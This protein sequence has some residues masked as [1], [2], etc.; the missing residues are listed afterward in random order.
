MAMLL[1]NL[2]QLAL[3]FSVW[4]RASVMPPDANGLLRVIDGGWRILSGSAVPSIYPGDWFWTA[5]RA[6]TVPPGEVGPITEFPFFTF[7]YGDLHAHMIA[8]PLALFALAWAVALA[9]RPTKFSR[10]G[11][12]A[13][14]AVGALA[15]GVLYPTNSWDFPTYLV[16]TALAILFYDW[17]RLGATLPMLGQFGVKTAV[18]AA[19]SIMLFWPFWQNFGSGYG[20]VKLWE[21]SLTSIGDYLMIYGLFLWLVV[22]FVVVEFK[23]WG[24][25][26]TAEGLAKYAGVSSTAVIGLFG[27]SGIMFGMLVRGY[28][29][30]PL[31]L[32]LVLLA[33]VLAVWGAAD[34]SRR[35]V[36]TLIASALALTLV[37]E[38]VVLDGDIGRM[39]TVFKF[40]MQVWILLSIAGGA[41]LAWLWPLVTAEWGET[42]QK[43]WQTV[44]VALLLSAVLYPILATRAKWAIRENP[45]QARTTLN[46][47]DFMRYVTYGDSGQNVSLN[48]DYEAIQWMHRNIPGSP[49]IAEAHSGNPYRS[50]GNRIS[51]YTGLPSIV[52]WD[53]HQRQQRTTTPGWLIGSRVN[54]VSLLYNTED[55][56]LAQELLEKYNVGYVYVGQLETVYYSPAGL[57]KFDQMAADGLLEEVYRNRGTSIYRVIR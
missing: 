31:I 54:D 25:R 16:I 20:S 34:T 30:A 10:L 35:V 18:L 33:G 11:G 43:L 38:V 56:Q 7:L 53:S 1:G 42:R 21:G 40:Y 55:I 22:T 39:N 45:E 44:L 51:M 23:G 19:S 8:L 46:S 14:G 24:Q 9:L 41:M 47:L 5:S 36:H 4:D 6:I 57:Y 37:V 48:Y 15:V 29:V 32:T 28:E 12:L 50:I 26:W 3:V 17:R 2:R 49:I 52:G 13:Y 27:V